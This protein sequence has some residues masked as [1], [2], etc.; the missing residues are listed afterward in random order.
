MNIKE[1]TAYRNN[2]CVTFFWD[3]S[4]VSFLTSLICSLSQ[5]QDALLALFVAA[6]SEWILL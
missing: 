3:G 5:A 6:P 2:T 1:L 4:S